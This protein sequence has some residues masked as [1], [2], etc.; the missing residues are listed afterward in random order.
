MRKLKG[1]HGWI[2]V[3]LGKWWVG[4]EYFPKANGSEDNYWDEFDIAWWG[5]LIILLQECWW[6]QVLSGSGDC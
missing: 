2:L 6:Y 1:S 3:G 4:G 5:H